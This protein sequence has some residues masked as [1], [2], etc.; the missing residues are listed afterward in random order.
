MSDPVE[1]LDCQGAVDR[2]YDYLDGEL[3]PEVEAAVRAHLA[4]CSRCFKL[5]GF[6]GAFLRFLEARTRAQGAPIALKRRI[7]DTLFLATDDAGSG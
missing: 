5:F 1:R 6:E 7:L 3:T 2:L 4:D